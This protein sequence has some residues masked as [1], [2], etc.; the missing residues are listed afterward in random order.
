M[1]SPHSQALSTYFLITLRTVWCEPETSCVDPQDLKG[2][3]WA[4]LFNS[5]VS[6]MVFLTELLFISNVLDL[7]MSYTVVLEKTNYLECANRNLSITFKCHF[8]I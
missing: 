5:F 7:L 6:C 2:L 8:S 1:A 3:A 4:D